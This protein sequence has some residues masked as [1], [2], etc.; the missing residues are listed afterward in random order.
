MFEELME[1]VAEKERFRIAANKLLNQCFLLRKKDDTKK[2]YVYIRE[3]RELFQN[4]FDLLGYRIEVN[5]D[6]GVIALKGEYDTGRLILTKMESIFLL[7]LRLLYIEKRKEITGSYEEVTV[8]ME[9]IREKYGILKI[10]NKQI[11]DKGMERRLVALFRRYNII[12]NIDADVNQADTR[13][14]IYPSILMAVNADDIN[15]YYEMTKKKL[16]EYAGTGN[17]NEEDELPEEEEI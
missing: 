14:L 7:I 5:E 12:K 11:M 2:E 17:S 16:K 1:S 6:Q 8:L 10:K 3:N 13:I 4:Y 15:Q 9:E